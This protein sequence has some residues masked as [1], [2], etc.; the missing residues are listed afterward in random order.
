MP[1]HYPAG[2]ACPLPE[3]WPK[4]CKGFIGCPKGC[5]CL[6]TQASRQTGT[7]FRRVPFTHRN[8]WCTECTLHAPGYRKKRRERCPRRAR[9]VFGRVRSTHRNR[10]CTECTLHGLPEKGVDQ[11]KRCTPAGCGVK[12]GRWIGGGRAIQVIVTDSVWLRSFS[13]CARLDAR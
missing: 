8:R 4:P 11:A 2:G 10:C 9:S 6:A 7:V 5:G 12:V 3:S 13:S 1:G